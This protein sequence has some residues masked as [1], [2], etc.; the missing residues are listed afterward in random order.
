MLF[1]SYFMAYCLLP[2][3]LNL[4]LQVPE[5]G[6]IKGTRETTRCGGARK[7]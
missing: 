1:V 3:A 5:M 6:T 7:W 2:W 4:V